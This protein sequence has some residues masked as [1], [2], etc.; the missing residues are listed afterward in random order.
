M[1]V[2]N[3]PLTLRPSKGEPGAGRSVPSEGPEAQP[4]IIR[5]SCAGR[6]LALGI[7]AP[8]EAGAQGWGGGNL[9]AGARGTAPSEKTPEGGWARP[10]PL[11]WGEAAAQRRVRGVRRSRTTS[12]SS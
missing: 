4:P 5:R 10:T 9:P 11:P 3:H 12:R 2:S 8:A 7:V 6:N 1:N